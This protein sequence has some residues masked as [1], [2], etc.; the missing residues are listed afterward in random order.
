MASISKFINMGL[1]GMLAAYIINVIRCYKEYRTTKKT[2]EIS[3]NIPNRDSRIEVGKFDGAKKD[4]SIAI[5]PFLRLYRVI[6]RKWRRGT[7]NKS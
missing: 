1:H 4:L 5:F 3:L 6:S 7:Q 2:L